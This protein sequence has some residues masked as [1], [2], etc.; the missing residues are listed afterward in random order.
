MTGEEYEA[1]MKARADKRQ[2]D[3]FACA[4]LTGLLSSP[5]FAPGAGRAQTLLEGKS[6]EELGATNA[7]DFK[8]TADDIVDYVEVIVDMTNEIAEKMMKARE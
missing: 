1:E 6:I 3:R 8:P 4:T 5:H 2:R 7:L